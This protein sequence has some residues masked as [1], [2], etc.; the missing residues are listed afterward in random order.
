V[1]QAYD[2][3]VPAPLAVKVT[4]AP[5]QIAAGLVIAAVGDEL[6]VTLL[7]ATSVHPAEL[8]TVTV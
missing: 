4:L 6:T 2:P 5:A 8:V 3:P 7:V 1:F